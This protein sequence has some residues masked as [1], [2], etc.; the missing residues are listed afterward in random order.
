MAAGSI[1]F[2][3]PA[4]ALLAY[5]THTHYAVQATWHKGYWAADMEH[6]CFRGWHLGV[7]LGLGL[8]SLLLLGIGIPILFAY[9]IWRHRGTLQE[10]STR[11]KM[12]F[13]YR[14]YK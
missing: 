13:A 11:E 3:C 9:M 2:A 14:S 5:H 4:L 10:S 8:P 12:G 7:T 6:A 1:C